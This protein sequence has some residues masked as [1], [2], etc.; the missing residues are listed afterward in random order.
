M[1]AKLL[2]LSLLF[3]LSNCAKQVDSSAIKSSFSNELRSLSSAD[4]AE[5]I[6][7]EHSE[8]IQLDVWGMN[9]LGNLVAGSE[10]CRLETAAGGKPMVTITLHGARPATVVSRVPME[11]TNF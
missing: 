6:F 8:G 10:T 5:L 4:S 11:T 7:A 2:L 9:V 3:V 1:R